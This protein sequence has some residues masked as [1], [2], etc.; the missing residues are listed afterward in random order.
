MQ[1]VAERDG[2]RKIF[3]GKPEIGGRFSALSDFGMVPA[4]VMGIDV[5]RLLRQADAMATECAAPTDQNESARLG[6]LLGTLA[7]QGRDK[8][9]F[10]VS[11]R[12][13]DLGAWLEQLIAESTG[14]NGTAIIPVDREPLGPPEVYGADRVF[15]YERL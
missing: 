10:I 4:A 6:I 13:H 2:F 14:K 1:N 3:F 5:A 9:T 12:I 11:P 8:L 7:R 15:L